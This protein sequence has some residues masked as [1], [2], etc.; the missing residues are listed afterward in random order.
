MTQELL[1]LHFTYEKTEVRAVVRPN[2]YKII[3]LYT[4]E[5]KLMFVLE[6]MVVC[7]LKPRNRKSHRLWR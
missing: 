5:E 2:R 3:T 4:R 6:V 7:I 1:L